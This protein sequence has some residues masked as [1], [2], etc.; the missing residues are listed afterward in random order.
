MASDDAVPPENVGFPGGKL[1]SAEDMLDAIEK[2]PGLSEESKQELRESI[3]KG[4]AGLGKLSEGFGAPAAASGNTSVEIL[5]L[6]GL[7]SLVFLILVFFG[8]KLYNSL[9]ERERRKEEKRKLKQQKK[10]K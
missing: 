3:L 7:I 4:A 5:M 2:M 10:K 9:V 6:L 1:P 8:Y